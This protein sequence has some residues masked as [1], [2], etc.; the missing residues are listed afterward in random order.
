MKPRLFY[1]KA[2]SY[3]RFLPLDTAMVLAHPLRRYFP[4]PATEVKRTDRSALVE[5]D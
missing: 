1:P 3:Q 2:V 5:S 4:S